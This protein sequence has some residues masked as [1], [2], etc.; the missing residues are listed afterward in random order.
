MDRLK[1]EFWDWTRVAGWTE[2]AAARRPGGASGV[3][4]GL[5]GVVLTGRSAGARLGQ[6]KHIETAEGLDAKN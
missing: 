3:A 5:G 4:N 1:R 6:D 2:G